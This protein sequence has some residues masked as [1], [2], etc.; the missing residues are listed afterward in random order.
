VRG[1]DI[2]R[3][4]EALSGMLLRHGG[5]PMA[6]GLALEAGRVAEFAAAF[7]ALADREVPDEA[8]VPR[9]DVDATLTLAAADAALVA[10]LEGLQPHGMGNPEPVFAVL[11]ARVRDARA[12]GADRTH[13]Q[14]TL[15]QDGT[16]IPAIWFGG[17]AGGPSAGDTLDVACSPG[18]D[19][20]TGGVRL[21]VRDV[22]P[23]TSPAV[24]CPPDVRRP[25]PDGPFDNGATP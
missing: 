10:A 13:L 20:R 24:S 12:V 23:T 8:L 9:V 5:H 21:K 2:G 3:A 6:A 18:R 25:T 17:A 1:F 7:E 11:G 14:L 22:R 19:D 4:L 15:E 16:S